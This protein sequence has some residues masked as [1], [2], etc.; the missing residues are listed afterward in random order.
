MPSGMLGLDTDFMHFPCVFFFSLPSRYWGKP[1]EIH[2]D[3]TPGWHCEDLGCT[4]D[5]LAE[6]HQASPKKSKGS[7]LK[8]M[9]LAL[10]Y[11]LQ[12]QDF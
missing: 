8:H 4:L 12:L 11:A 3:P 9:V 7:A 2:P 6:N 10:K 1:Q 5:V